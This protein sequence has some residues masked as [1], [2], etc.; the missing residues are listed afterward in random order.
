[1]KVV[2][3]ISSDGSM[4]LLSV[5]REVVELLEV[6]AIEDWTLVGIRE[7]VLGVVI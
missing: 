2:G 5:L 4:L 1:M 3:I 7:V 6:G